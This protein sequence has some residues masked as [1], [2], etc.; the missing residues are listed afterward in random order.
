VTSLDIKR[1]DIDTCF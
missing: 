1:N